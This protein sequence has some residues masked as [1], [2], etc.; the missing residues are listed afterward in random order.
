MNSKKQLQELISHIIKTT[1]KELLNNSS[2]NNNNSQDKQNNVDINL[3]KPVDSMTPA[4]RSKYERDLEKQRRDDVKQGEAE[5]KSAKAEM[6][7]FKKKTDQSKRF[8]I[9]DLQKKLQSLK[10]GIGG[11]I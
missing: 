2:F 11:N 6:D 10:G 9:P 1:I 4:E 3:A 8:R 5:L 7:F